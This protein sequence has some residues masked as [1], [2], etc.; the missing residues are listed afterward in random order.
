MPP[1]VSSISSSQRQALL[2]AVIC[3]CANTLISLALNVQKLAHLR[4]QRADG[5]G[6]QEGQTQEEGD[7][8]ANGHE[9]TNNGKHS[10]Q[11][12][13]ESSHSQAQQPNTKFLKSKLWWTGMGLMVIGEGGNFVSYGFAP[14]S[15]VAPLGSVALLANVFLAPLLLH[16]RFAKMDLLGVALASLGAAGVVVAASTIPGGSDEGPAGPDALW[17][18]VCQ[19]T[20]LTYAAVLVGLAIILA[21]TSTT[22]F[23]ERYILIDVG[24][25]ATIGGFTVL[26]TKGLSS[27]LSW[28][29]NDKG[30]IFEAFKSWISYSLLV[31]LVGTALIQIAFLNRAL[32]RFDA[33]KGEQT[34]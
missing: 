3:I 27:L 4:Q 23:G 2:G 16:E 15:L 29:A 24:A 19:R 17:S 21:F 12:S 32:Q 28:G 8:N 30:N 1:G 34:S 11:H 31:L 20:F 26:S 6:A 22:R 25:C 13:E 10:R 33:R 18:S 7:D 5:R 14:A 9:P